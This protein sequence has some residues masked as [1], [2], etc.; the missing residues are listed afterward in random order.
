MYFVL[1]SHG[2]GEK[3]ETETPFLIWGAGI[4][5]KP[6]ETEDKYQLDIE[7]S[8]PLYF[9]EQAQMTPLMSALLGI[10]TPMNNFG[11]LPRHFLNS[12]VEYEF[13]AAQNNAYQLLEQYRALLKQHEQGW[14]TPFLPKFTTD[15]DID[16]MKKN[17]E[18]DANLKS[19]SHALDLT[20][21]FMAVVLKGIDYYFGYYRWPLLISTTAT[22]VGFLCHLLML[23]LDT[24]NSY[25]T[26]RGTTK[27]FHRNRLLVIGI[28]LIVLSFCLLQQLAVTVSI[29]LLMPVVVWFLLASLRGSSNLLVVFSGKQLLALISCSELLV[30]T[31]FERR[32][33]SLGFILFTL[34][35]K[36]DRNAYRHKLKF[37]TSLLFSVILIIFPLLPPSVGYS[38]NYLLYVGIFL[39]IL[40]YFLVKTHVNL[41]DVVVVVVVLTNAALCIY[42]HAQ[43]L[44]VYLVSQVIS[45]GFLIYVLVTLV[46]PSELSIKNRLERLIFLLTSLYCLLCTSY[47]AVFILLLITELISLVDSENVQLFQGMRETSSAN[48]S[49]SF[50][51]AFIMLLY[52]FFSFFGTGNIASVSSFDPNIIRCFLTTFS[53]FVIMF[54]VILK[55]IIP[56]LLIMSIIFALSPFVIHYEREIFI[57]L[58]ILCDI[59]GLNFL[60]LVKNQGSWLEIGSSISHFVIMQVTT[61]VLVVFVYLSKMLLKIRITRRDVSNNFLGESMYKLK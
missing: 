2:A 20:Y 44:G 35:D 25:A 60:F 30:Y 46:R 52:T 12:S 11:T 19:F 14:L 10:A 43:Q 53:P 55:L 33:I 59:M 21:E 42:M 22:F 8:R 1:G 9:M 45:W 47:E 49:Q 54:L 18:V 38:N 5:P 37:F 17:I 4:N 58:L 32:A 15:I 40:R 31:F 16:T 34:Y 23:L 57:C 56:L 48:L 13:L 51:Y 41:V 7:N 39:I 61:V 24:K 6:F 29:Y 3:H 27:A 28:G 36:I 26:K 50:R